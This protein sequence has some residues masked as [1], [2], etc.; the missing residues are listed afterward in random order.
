MAW[1]RAPVPPGSNSPKYFGSSPVEPGGQVNSCTGAYNR[2][3]SSFDRC[4]VPLLPI[5]AKGGVLKPQNVWLTLLSTNQHLYIVVLKSWQNVF[6][7]TFK[8]IFVHNMFWTCIF[9]VCTKLVIHWTIFRHIVGLSDAR[10]SASEKD[11]L[12]LIY[13]FTRDKFTQCVLFE[14]LE[15]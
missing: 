4:L 1:P 3:T 2:E 9:L 13:S 15:Q 5:R 7:L 8:T 12:L 11:L 14:R 10:M 6:D